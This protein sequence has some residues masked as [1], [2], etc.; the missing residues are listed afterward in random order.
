MPFG[1]GADD[2]DHVQGDVQ[3]Q[4]GFGNQIRFA[5]EIITPDYIPSLWQAWLGRHVAVP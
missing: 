3:Q 4:K 5:D 1:A 2:L